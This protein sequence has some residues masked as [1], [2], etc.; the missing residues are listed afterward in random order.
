M[1]ILEDYKKLGFSKDLLYLYS[2]KLFLDFGAN[3]FGLFLPIFLY[4]WN[5]KLCP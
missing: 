5:F 1:K 4:F 2:G 3:V